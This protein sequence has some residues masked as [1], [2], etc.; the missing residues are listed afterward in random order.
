MKSATSEC[1]SVRNSIQIT[2]CTAFVLVSIQLLNNIDGR[3]T[4]YVRFTM[5]TSG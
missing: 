4:A 5:T 1:R 3:R 2:R